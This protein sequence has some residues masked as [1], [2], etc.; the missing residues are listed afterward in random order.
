LYS[1]WDICPF[2]LNPACAQTLAALR[3]CGKGSAPGAEENPAAW[4][5]GGNFLS[6]ADEQR[7]Q[8]V[9]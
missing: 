5:P 9:V 1:L 7:S 8:D 3:I 2:A 4:L 6:G